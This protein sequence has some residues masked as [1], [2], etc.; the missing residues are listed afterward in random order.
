MNREKDNDQSTDKLSY[1]QTININGIKSNE[2]LKSIS[3]FSAMNRKIAK[4]NGSDQNLS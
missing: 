4:E 1:S 3:D 2:N